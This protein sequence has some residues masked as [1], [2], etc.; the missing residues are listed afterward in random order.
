MRAW[1]FLVPLTRRNWC[2]TNL[3]ESKP[4]WSYAETVPPM[5]AP[6]SKPPTPLLSF[7]LFFTFI[8]KILHEVDMVSEN[9]S[10]KGKFL[11]S[12]SPISR[13]GIPRHRMKIFL[14]AKCEVDRPVDGEE[15]Q[16]RKGKQEER[17]FTVSGTE[18]TAPSIS[19]FRIST[20]QWAHEI[21]PRHTALSN[22]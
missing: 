2:E 21:L 22:L 8:L 20:A 6:L 5:K 10:W 15:G 12:D 11:V 9:M 18:P 19:I 4:F 14:I 7:F 13:D 16:R 17:C 1:D 3:E